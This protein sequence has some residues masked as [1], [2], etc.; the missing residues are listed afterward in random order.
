MFSYLPVQILAAIVSG[1]IALV[2]FAGFAL[3]YVEA[4]LVYMILILLIS[5]IPLKKQQK[6]NSEFKT[7]SSF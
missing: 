1:G 6:F 3:F 2:F 5:L 7:C 4:L